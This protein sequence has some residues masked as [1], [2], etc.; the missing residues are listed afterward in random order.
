MIRIELLAAAALAFASCSAGAQTL[1]HDCDAAAGHSSEL[2]RIQAGGSFAVTGTIEPRALYRNDADAADATGSIWLRAPDG[3]WSAQI[4][5]GRLVSDDEL[6]DREMFA[7]LNTI[8]GETETAGE[9]GVVELGK[10]YG[11]SL[12]VAGGH[13]RATLE[14]DYVPL[15]S[16]TSTFEVPAT[17]G[18]VASI[19]C[20]GGAFRFR[21]L[22]LGHEQP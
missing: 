22:D 4:E 3:S 16:K 18:A 17:D 12:I 1:D 14:G 19:V 15:E 20:A 5:I 21:N 11:F 7:S 9:F 10:T 13:G 6:T 2:K 8:A